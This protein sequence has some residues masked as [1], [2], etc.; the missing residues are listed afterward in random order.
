MSTGII[1][2]NFGEP[3]EPDLDQ[4]IS[5][6][7]RIFTNSG[8][9]RAADPEAYRA[10]V[11][12]LAERR[13]PGLLHEYEQI[14]GSPLN[15]QADAQA[16]RLGEELRSRGHDVE[17][18]SAFQFTPPFVKETVDRARTEGMNRIVGLPVY[19]LCGHSTTVAALGQLRRAVEEQ[20]GWEPDL[21]ELSGWHGHPDFF[22]FHADHIRDHANSQGID[23]TD[24]GTAFLFSIHG[25]PLKYLEHGNR[26]DRY[27]EEACEGI[28]ARLGLG[29][30][31]MGYQNHTNRAIEWT[32]PD[33]EVVVKGL[34]AKR[35]VVMPLA[36]M[37]EQSETLAE[38]DHDLRDEAVAIGLDFHRIPV[39][40]DSPRFTT[41]L[42]DLVEAGIAADPEGTGLAL[43]R[44]LCR[45]GGTALCTNGMRL[46][47]KVVR[48]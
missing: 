12:A 3:A 28:A 46:N 15:P 41:I 4:V 37:H 19:P 11:R 9:E 31:H 36:F 17:C 38:L 48:G 32:Q 23:L 5:F 33:V 18:Y 43:R 30:Y 40:H 27:V 13:A 24:P 42:A 14:G 22:D 35:V 20:D 6:L 39:P 29:T 34:E 16:E 7:E 45:S 21:V 2:I 26:Y 25:T 44:C 8:L 1:T 47:S 10:H